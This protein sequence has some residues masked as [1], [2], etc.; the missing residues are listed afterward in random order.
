MA[1]LTTDAEVCNQAMILIG[2]QRIGSLSAPANQR[3]RD[4]ASVYAQARDSELRRVKWRF[5]QHEASLSKDATYTKPTNSPWVARYQLPAD[6]IRAH[7]PAATGMFQVRGRY[8][9]AQSD[10]DT[11][12]L[13]YTRQ[14]T[15]VAEFDVHFMDALAAR[16]AYILSE[17]VTQSTAKR[18]LAQEHYA[19]A[20]RDAKRTNAIETQAE[21][22]E[23]P[24]D[25][26]WADING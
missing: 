11:F 15:T 20:L 25:W 14:I 19:M 2:G 13:S 4:L 10:D 8:V 3:E 23:T 22:T 6:C 26:A 12:L 1:G 21:F 7:L 16:I 24:T 18:Q 17:Q 9:Y 5:A